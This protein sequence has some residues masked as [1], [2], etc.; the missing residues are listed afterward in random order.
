MIVAIFTL[1][2]DIFHSNKDSD[3]IRLG[4]SRIQHIAMDY[5]LYVFLATMVLGL[6]LIFYG[7]FMEMRRG[8]KR[9]LVRIGLATGICVGAFV[10]YLVM[11][12][13][14]QC[15]WLDLAEGIVHCF[16]I[17][18]ILGLLIPVFLGDISLSKTK[19]EQGGDGDA[20]ETV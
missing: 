12:P 5:V 10:G 16:G 11:P 2:C 20:E 7:V 4:D 17:T 8:K 3:Y 9:N 19:S 15:S 13:L 1:V 14:S 18:L 6:P